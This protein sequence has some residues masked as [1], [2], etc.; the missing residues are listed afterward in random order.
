MGFLKGIADR[1]AKG[2]NLKVELGNRYQETYSRYSDEQLIMF[3]REICVH[4][5]SLSSYELM[6]LRRELQ[7]RE[8][9]N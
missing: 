2:I 7:N 6:T 1:A 8:L 4:K 3:V 9:I 5:R